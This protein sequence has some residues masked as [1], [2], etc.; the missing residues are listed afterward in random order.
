MEHLKNTELLWKR[1]GCFQKLEQE[2][3]IQQLDMINKDKPTPQYKAGDLVY[4]I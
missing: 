4:L 3:R 2:Y 1:F